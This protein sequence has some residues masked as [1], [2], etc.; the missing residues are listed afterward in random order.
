MRP[1]ILLL[2]LLGLFVAADG[3][4]RTHTIPLKAGELYMRPGLHKAAIDSFNAAIDTKF[5]KSVLLLRFRQLPGSDVQKS[6]S[7]QG[8]TLLQYVTDNVYLASVS[9]KLNADGLQRSDVMAMHPW[10]PR[11]KLSPLLATGKIPAYA[12]KATGTMDVHVLIPGSFSIVEA[13]S[14]LSA[15]NY[16]IVDKTWSQFGQLTLRISE[17]QL[18]QL[19]TF[20]FVQYIEPVGKEPEPL[21]FSGRQLSNTTVLNAPV[22]EGGKGLNGEGVVVGIGDIG[23]VPGHIDFAGRL[24]SR[25]FL[26]ETHGMQV[27]GTAVGGGVVNERYRGY[28]SKATMISESQ[29]QIVSRTP[30]YFR[31]YGMVVTNNSYGG[32]GGCEY[33]GMYEMASRSIDI[34]SLSYQQ[35]LHV[36]AAGNN[37]SWNCTP[38]PQ[39]FYTIVPGFQSAKNVLTVGALND[40]GTAAAFTSKGPAA[41]GRLKP[42]IT[43]KGAVVISTAPGNWYT[44]G[45][46]TS[47]AAPAVTGGVALLCQRYRQLHNNSNPSNAL[48]KALLCN[49]ADDKGN[50]GPDFTYGF[51]SMNLLRS[52]EAMEKEQFFIS[53]LSNGANN[54]HTITIPANTAQVKVMLYWNDP[55]ALPIGRQML[56]NDLDAELITPASQ[57]ILPKIPDTIAANV[58]N[59]AINGADHINNIEQLIIDQPTAGTYT[60]RVKGTAIAQGPQDYVLVYDILPSSLNVTYPAGADAIVPGENILLRWEA[61]T[62]SGNGFD[63]AYSIDNGNNWTTI[64]TNISA[65][66]RFYNWQVPNLPSANARIRISQSGSG[67]SATSQRFTILGWPVVT[68]DPIQ[69]EGSV[70]IN[71]NNI[72]SA[73]DYEVMLF[74]GNDWQTAGITNNTTWH[75]NA[76]SKD[77]VYWVTVRARIEGR[78]GVRAIAMSRKPNSGDCSSSLF[79]NDL[80]ID[81][82]LSPVTGRK[83]TSTEL[84]AT[85]AVKLQIKNLDNAPANNF[86]V[87][88]SVNGGAWQAETINTPIAANA[89]YVYEFAATTDLSP[90]GTYTLTAVVKNIATDLNT[91][92]DTLRFTFRQLDNQPIPVTTAA[93]FTDDLEAAADSTYTANTTGIAGLDRYDFET[94]TGFG[95]LRTLP[96]SDVP[97]SGRNSFVLG[98]RIRRAFNQRGLNVLTG[99]YNL[100]GKL[101]GTNDLRLDFSYLLATAGLNNDVWIR[102]SDTDPWIRIFDFNGNLTP[103]FSTVYKTCSNV[104]ITDSLAK[105]G[106]DFSSSFQVRWR[107]SAIRNPVL[108]SAYSIDDIKLFE[109][110]NDL[111]LSKI[112]HPLPITCGLNA[113]APVMVSV[114]NTNN[115]ALTNIPVRYSINNGPWV[116]E[117][118]PSIAANT[119][120]QYQF[121]QTINLA[122]AGNYTI[123]TVVT[124]PG[125][126]YAANDTVLLSFS[127][128]MLVTNFPYLQ[129]FESGKGG[130]YAEGTNSSWEYGTP[131]SPLIN[132]AASGTKAW[133]T[134]LNGHYNDNEKSFLYSPCYLLDGM[135]NPA[136]SI[137]MAMQVKGCIGFCDGVGFEY[138]HNGGPWIYVVTLP[139]IINWYNNISWSNVEMPLWHVAS[140]K[141]PV[142]TGTIRFR[143]IM[144]ADFIHDGEGVAIDDIHIYDRAKV[145]Y[146][147][148]TMTSPVSKPVSGNQWIDFESDGELIA[149]IHPGG[150][151]LGNTDVQAFINTDAVRSAGSQYYHDRNIT[152]KPQ[153]NP[154]DSVTVRLYYLDAEFNKL[155]N[156]SGCALCTKPV[157]AYRLGISQFKGATRAVENGTISDNDLP[158]TWSFIPSQQLR[159]VPFDTGYYAEFKVK[160]LSEFWLNSGGLD[161]SSA[162]IAPVFAFTAE[163]TQGSDV[164]VKWTTGNENEIV[165]YEIELAR[166]IQDLQENHFVKIAESQARQAS[167]VQ[168]YDYTDR[169]ADKFGSR[170]YRLKILYNNNSFRYSA[171]REVTFDEALI[172]KIYPN[173]SPGKF[174]LVLKTSTGNKMSARVMNMAGQVIRRYELPA[175]GFAQTLAV[176]LT[177]APA[178]IYTLQVE[179]GGQLQRFKLVKIK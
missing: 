35:V 65:S 4:V 120:L 135:T 144:S 99:T 66:R 114:Y 64:A 74:R 94:A 117:T 12:V 171:V 9:G 158:G 81:S 73:T 179:T 119:K 54:T 88:Y 68:L 100:A 131:A 62:N 42:E 28:A 14:F 39:S 87:Q 137:S 104:E 150:Q 83:F 76:L 95:A 147:S 132:S 47:L 93:A 153:F 116:T 1:L 103:S 164:L 31:D 138:S 20:P 85:H 163:R 108:S 90:I 77:S 168:L 58:N 45:N 107:E 32:S 165:R 10:L 102:G 175:T 154:T 15:H 56:I 67:L 49:G 59:P 122:T 33:N 146:D 176:D 105:Y 134:S 61:F 160:D 34:M 151:N 174:N 149:S 98:E 17:K 178:G 173:P 37:G 8:I 50:P 167:T 111:Q 113:A 172:G 24:I 112:D 124:Y 26:G 7:G 148:T 109:V 84:S 170:Y 44:A 128:T 126:T 139:G 92:N 2:A 145:I 110:V 80:A 118:I 78:A 63:L 27:S 75:F 91:Q 177:A 25:T 21:T 129:D 53:S 51:G 52:V 60:I 121:T 30:V 23:D 71:W 133:K 143:F 41:D 162:L 18:Q 140:T 86:I 166:N 125:D 46:G 89:G 96:D 142:K 57:T 55:A 48:V 169:E 43:A 82:V 106:Q 72:L 29:G 141:L 136:L 155:L 70:V 36:I 3:Q 130:W 101:A 79:D 115:T 127:N 5:N 22:S 97:N 161:F 16:V 152:I 19:A 40:T 157:N 159:H 13:E 123:K 11:L 38:F 6:L 156:A 69:C